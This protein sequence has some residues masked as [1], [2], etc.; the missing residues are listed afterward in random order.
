MIEVKTFSGLH[1]TLPREFLLQLD[2]VVRRLSRAT[3]IHVELVNAS[4][5]AVSYQLPDGKKFQL[6]HQVVKVDSSVNAVT[7]YPATGQTIRGATS[8]AL[9]SQYD[10]AHLTFCRDTDDWVTL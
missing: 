3:G 2:D 10:S 1:P 5:G 8:H 9:S 4:A 6:D 7:I